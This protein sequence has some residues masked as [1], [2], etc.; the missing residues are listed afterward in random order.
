MHLGLSMRMNKQKDERSEPREVTECSELLERLVVY[1]NTAF[2]QALTVIKLVFSLVEAVLYP[3]GMASAFDP[4]PTSAANVMLTLAQLLFAFDIVLKFFLAI[5]VESYD[6]SKYTSNLSV[7]STTYVKTGFIADLVLALPLGFLGAGLSQH[8][9]VL[10]LIKVARARTFFSAFQPKLYNEQ[11]RKYYN[12]KVQEVLKNDKLKYSII[13]SNNY[14]MARLKTQNCM[15][16][17]RMTMIV[18]GL[19]YC[20]GIVWFLIVTVAS[21]LEDPDQDHFVTVYGLNE[22]S[23]VEA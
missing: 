1:P 23:G 9:K 11:I 20:T 8:F 4:D 18:V 15:H 5:K 16:T 17:Y 14:I 3:Y 13:D 12:R 2:Y 22:S 10:H 19:V 6:D 7:I 21:E